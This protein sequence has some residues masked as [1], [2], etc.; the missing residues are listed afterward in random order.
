MSFKNW[1][2]ERIAGFATLSSCLSI[3]LTLSLWLILFAGKGDWD[4]H[5]PSNHETGI[6]IKQSR[7]SSDLRINVGL[8]QDQSTYNS[9]G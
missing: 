1:I 4:V 9:E 7:R 5:R 2:E 6:C 3:V 8:V